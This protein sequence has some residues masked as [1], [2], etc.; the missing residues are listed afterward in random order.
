MGNRGGGV[1]AVRAPET[2]PS[3]FPGSVDGFAAA[4]AAGSKI[5]MVTSYDAWSAR[6]S[7]RTR[8]STACLWA[9]AR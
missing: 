2:R 9:T 1:S 5:V 7:S 3:P 8:P 6:V 4:K